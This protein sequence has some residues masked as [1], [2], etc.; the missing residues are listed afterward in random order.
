MSYEVHDPASQVVV[1]PGSESWVRDDS[2]SE[3]FGVVH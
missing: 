1:V 2:E 3:E